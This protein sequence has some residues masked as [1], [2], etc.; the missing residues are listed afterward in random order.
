MRP[1]CRGRLARALLT[2]RAQ[3]IAQG[4]RHVVGSPFRG[5]RC[6]VLPPRGPT[7]FDMKPAPASPI[8]A[9]LVVLAGCASS[10]GHDRLHM[11][12]PPP[13]SAAP[14]PPPARIPHVAHID[15]SVE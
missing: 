7:L 8:F 1:T 10:D 4:R 13:Q 3:R 6:P 2:R 5:G 11:S 9:S 12:R 15:L 14:P